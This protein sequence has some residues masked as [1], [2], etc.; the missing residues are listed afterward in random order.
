MLKVPPTLAL[1]IVAAAGKHLAQALI[2][3]NAALIPYPIH[4]EDMAHAL[5]NEARAAMKGIDL[6]EIIADEVGT[7]SDLSALTREVVGE[8][9]ERDVDIERAFDEAKEDIERDLRREAENID[10]DELAMDMVREVLSP[11]DIANAVREAATSAADDAR[12][13]A[14][15]AAGLLL[16]EATIRATTDAAATAGT[17]SAPTEAASPTETSVACPT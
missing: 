11:A 6:R 7:A 3:S 4:P 2:D 15:V 12:N 5:R 13:A 10:L 9:V 14:I 17:A 16:A 1:I 8:I